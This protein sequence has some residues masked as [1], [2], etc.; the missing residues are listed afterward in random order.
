[1][2][3]LQIVQNVNRS[4]ECSSCGAAGIAACDCGA[5]YMPA[6]ARA[7]KAIAAN[8]GKSARALSVETGISEATLRRASTASF[9]AV[10]TTTPQGLVGPDGITRRQG[11]DGKWRRMPQRKPKPE[12]VM[13]TDEEAEASFQADL[14]DQACWLL[15][16]MA[17]S[18]RRKFFAHLR[19][20]H[21]D[22]YVQK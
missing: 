10:G 19:R 3:Q 12:E 9:D 11:L 22:D 17:S 2:A 13:P 5:P 7:A 6:S 20:K 4:M 15:E 8:P 14:Y 18:T 21:H 1:M 16:Q